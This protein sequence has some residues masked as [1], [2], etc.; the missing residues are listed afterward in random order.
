[1]V[2]ASAMSESM[3][4]IVLETVDDLVRARRVNGAL[5]VNLPLLYPDGSFVTV[6]IDQMPAGFHV[7]DHGFAYREADDVGYSRSFKRTANK[8][9]EG[10]AVNVGDRALFIN[11]PPEQ[12]HR[13][14]CEVAQVSRD[15]AEFICLRAFDEDE[16]VLADELNERLVKVFGHK[17]VSG[18]TQIIGAS[19]TEWNVSS[20]VVAGDHKAVFQAV[21]PFANSI[22][23]ASTAF[24]DL[25]ALDTPPRLV[26]VVRERKSLGNKL[27]L[28]APGRVIEQA[29]ADDTFLRAAA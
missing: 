19:T 28:L 27:P 12:L 14:I 20:L 11:S 22:Y 10:T 5:F 25:A 26:A 4:R 23:K 2:P 29:Q 3:E 15:V 13:S 9:A 21:S 16:E 18:E 6:K 1:M 8:M 7:S 24:R 17:N